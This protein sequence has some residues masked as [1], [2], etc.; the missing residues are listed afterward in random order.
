MAPSAGK[1]PPGA[2]GLTNI[3]L[4]EM[5]THNG[6]DASANGWQQPNCFVKVN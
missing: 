5:S 3:Q 6:G 4:S 2:H 1:S